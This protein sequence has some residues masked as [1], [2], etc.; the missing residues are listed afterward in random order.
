MSKTRIY[1]YRISQNYHGYLVTV[2]FLTP[3]LET[4]QHLFD[5]LCKIYFLKDPNPTL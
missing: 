5:A 2:T 4:N 1:F 3:Q